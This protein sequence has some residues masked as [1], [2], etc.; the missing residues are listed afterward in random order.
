MST[1]AQKIRLGVFMIMATL[2]FLG[3]IMILAG[4]KLW[5]PKDRYY[6]RFTES[7]SGLEVGSTVKMKGV[8]VGQVEK[9]KI[10]GDVESVQVTLALTP[11]TPVPADTRAVMTSIGIT[12]QQFIELTGGTQRA[13]RIPPNTPGSFVQE[14]KGTLQSLTGKAEDIAMKMESVLNNVLR[15][16]DEEGRTRIKRLLDDADQLAVSWSDMA[17]TNMPRVKHIIANLDR[18]TGLLEKASGSVAKL[19]EEN[20]PHVREMLSSAAAAAHSLQ[21]MAQSLNPQAT[22]NAIAGAANSIKRRVDDPA[23]SATIAS[24]Q[25]AT[26]RLSALASELS[27][28]VKQRDRQLSMVME[29]LDRTTAN[30]KEFSRVIKERPSLLLRGETRK[31]RNVP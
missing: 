21:K 22:L 9:I 8:R 27:R 12:G 15:I 13:P 10:G 24:M 16:T 19:A 23:L 18:T 11:H 14:G 3:S 31:E 30:L 20:A 17:T 5:N 29:N 26:N 1:R 7:I 28:V 2:L 25:T 6:V 4:L